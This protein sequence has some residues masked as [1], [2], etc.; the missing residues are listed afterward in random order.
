MNGLRARD[1]KIVKSVAIMPAAT[2][3][4]FVRIAKE[5]SLSLSG[6]LVAAFLWVWFIP[7]IQ[8]KTSWLI[9][10]PPVPSVLPSVAIY[11]EFQRVDPYGNIVDLDKATPPREIISPAVPRNAHVSFHVAVTIPPGENFFLFVVPNPLDACGVDM[12]REQFVQTAHGWIPDRLVQLHSLPDFGFMPDPD[13]NIPGQNTRVYLLDLWIPPTATPPGFRIEIQMKMGYFYVRPLE[14]RVIPVNIPNPGAGGK[15]SNV[16]L[17]EIAASADVSAGEVLKAY[18]SH[19]TSSPDAR[20]GTVRDIIRRN[21][22]QDMML[23]GA[24]D[25]TQTGPRAMK[26]VWKSI[27][28]APGAEW[29]LRIRDYLYRRAAFSLL[30]PIGA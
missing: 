23:A 13:Q 15:R 1:V 29:Y 11:S 9:Q 2:G 22:I 7:N 21:A 30:K 10:E 26:R 24:L 18:I 19:R 3:L 16:P 14:V 6:S 28:V 5:R 12:Y 17:A 25:K 4:V 20:P 8:A 27:P